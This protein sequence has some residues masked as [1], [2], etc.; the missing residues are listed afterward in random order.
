MRRALQILLALLIAAGSVWWT[1]H[2][3]YQPERIL[4]ALPV[5]STVYVRST[6]LAA[7]WDTLLRHP[8]AAVVSVLNGDD[9]SALPQLAAD[10][11]TRTWVNR[12]LSGASAAAFSPAYGE[13]SDPAW[14][15]VTW[16][17]AESVRLRLLL[18]VFG[19]P[20]IQRM[21]VYNGRNIWRVGGEGGRA[22][23][24]MFSVAEGLVVATF[25]RDITAIRHALDSLDH[26]EPSLAGDRN[27]FREEIE[28]WAGATP[29]HGYA[30]LPNRSARGPLGFRL[31][32]DAKGNPG[33]DLRVAVA[34]AASTPTASA[35]PPEGLDLLLGDLPVALASAPPEVAVDLLGL[36][37]PG[38]FSEIFGRLVMANRGGPSTLGLIGGEASGSLSGKRMPLLLFSAPVPDAQHGVT[39]V[40]Q[41]LEDVRERFGVTFVLEPDDAAPGV[42]F[43]LNEN[44]TT[45]FERFSGDDR[46][47]VAVDGKRLVFASN[48]RALRFLLQRLGTPAAAYEAAKARWAAE[49]AAQP[50]AGSGWIDLARAS[51]L[52]GE[53]IDLQSAILTMT[54]PADL[55]LRLRELDRTR[56]AWDVAA[57]LRE[58][59][60]RVDTSSGVAAVIR[61][62][63]R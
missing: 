20:G 7:Q 43:S 31:V 21:P 2:E 5:N 9:A 10:A 35:R 54:N 63:A 62:G 59:S 44:G 13:L 15:M 33:L 22:P 39:S 25:S 1:F 58:V 12:L 4:R 47:A 56:T 18:T 48:L 46:L 49:Q 16:G 51:R 45:A 52:M 57:Q 42:L 40:T 37:W 23:R 53:Y 38:S 3:P 32:N 17:G 19:S 36:A 8:A 26:L 41:A 50:Q 34:S 11:E 28:T 14:V 30:W 6:N 61:M 55:D 27:G 60:A 24:L 29:V